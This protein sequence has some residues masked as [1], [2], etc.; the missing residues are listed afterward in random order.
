M[1]KVLIVEDNYQNA[2]LVISLLKTMG[3]EA[4]YEADGRQALNTLKTLIPQLI[5]LDLRLPSVDG[6][7]LTRRIKSDARLSHVPVVAVSVEVEPD[8]RITAFQAGCEA[9]FA[10]PVNIQELKAYLRQ[11]LR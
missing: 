7:E 4:L 3:Y 10:K 5:V 2:Q 8:D 1:S 11:R 9:Y 6:W